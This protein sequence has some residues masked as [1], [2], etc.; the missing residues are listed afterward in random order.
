VLDLLERYGIRATFF[1]QGNDVAAYPTI[2]S[3]IRSRGHAIG[4]H[5]YTHIDLRSLSDARVVE[6]LRST[7]DAIAAATGGFRPRC[8]RPPFGSFDQRVT[9]LASRE[10]LTITMWTHDTQDWNPSTPVAQILG[11]LNSVPSGAGST[12]NVL[13]HDFSPNMLTALQQWL[14]A[15]IGRY[16]FRVVPAC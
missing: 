1:I 2:T 16:D 10:G 12:S 9:D 4:N 8:M 14:P 6:E 3:S 13:M 7:Q 5:T 11:V 15:N